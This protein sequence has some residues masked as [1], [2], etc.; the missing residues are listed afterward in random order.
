[1]IRDRYAFRRRQRSSIV[2]ELIDERFV[3]ST[4]DVE[5]RRA[6]V[7][8]TLNY[9]DELP[10][11]AR[12]SE[13]VAHLRHSPVV[14][15]AG[16]TGSGKTTQIPLALIEA[17]YGIS[18]MIG[19][20]QPRRLAARSVA[21]RIATQMAVTL[22]SE[23]GYAVRFDDQWSSNTLIK[24]M[25]DGLLLAE[26]SSD[27]FLEQYEVLI[28]DEVHERSVNVDFLLGLMKQLLGR[29]GDLKIVLASA[30][31]DVEAFS[32]HFGN[33][34]TVSVQGR[35][36]PVEVVYR[37]P[38][39]HLEAEVLDILTALCREDSEN[40]RDILM[41]LAT[42]REILE[43]ARLIRGRFV[44]A[45][46]VLPLYARLP[47][48]EQ[49]RIFESSKRQRI[50]LATNVAE[51]SLT[52]PGIKY[53]IDL[54]RARINRY[55]PRA[56][57]NRLPIEQISQASADQRSG[58]CGR[59]GPGTC[60]RIYDESEF[61][62]APRYTL[63]EI[64]RS[65]LAS[66]M[67]QGMLLRLGD[68]AQFPFID[69]P[70]RAAIVEA[71]K[72]LTELSAIRN[73]KLTRTGRLMARLPVDP[74]LG[75]MLIEASSRNALS[76]VLIIVAALAAQDP[77]IRPLGNAEKAD[78]AHRSYIHEKS[79][80]LSLL[81]LWNKLEVQRRRLSSSQFSQHL[82]RQFIAKSRYFEW[83]QLHRQLERDCRMLKLK[84]NAKAASYRDV[85]I[86][87]LSGSIRFI[88]HHIE[89]T[90]YQCT[91]GFECYL[92]PGE[93]SRGIKPSWIVIFEIVE[94]SRTYARCV[95]EVQPRW[96]EEVSADLLKYS[97]QDPFWDQKRAEAMI[98]C[99]AT[100]FGLTVIRRRKV[101]LAPVDPAKAREIFI[102]NA[103]VNSKSA[104][105]WDFLENN[106]RLF[107]ELN[108]VQQR[109]RTNDLLISPSLRRVYYEKRIPTHVVN[110]STFDQWYKGASKTEKSALRMTAEDML[111]R[112]DQQ[113]DHN[114]FPSTLV[115]DELALPLRYRYAPGEIDD[116][117][118]I[119]LT[120][121]N[122]HD[123]SQTDLDWLVP[124]YLSR[125][126]EE[127]LRG[128]P[129]RMRKQLL[130]IS[131][132]VEEL[133]SEL[134]AGDIYRRKGFLDT[135]SQLLA[136]NFNINATVSDLAS[137]ALSPLVRMN[138]QLRDHRGKL[139][140]QDRILD[141]LKRRVVAR[142]NQDLGQQSLAASQSLRWTSFPDHGITRSKTIKAG[143]RNYTL[144]SLLRD[145]STSVLQK[146]QPEPPISDEINLRAMCR[147][148]LLAES[149]AVRYLKKEFR[150]EE[151][152]QLQFATIGSG[153]DLFQSLLLAAAHRA[154]LHSRPL[155]Y[156]KGVFDDLVTS[157]KG[158]LI[159]TAMN[160]LECIKRVLSRRSDLTKAISNMNTSLLSEARTDLA[161][162]LDSLIYADFV[163]ETPIHRFAHLEDYLEGMDYRL[164]SLQGG[165]LRDTQNM[166]ELHPIEDRYRSLEIKNPY[167]NDVRELRF[168]IE[169]YR[170]SLFH[171]R[172][173]SKR[174]IRKKVIISRLDEL[175]SADS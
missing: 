48:K 174:K 103:L 145:E 52:V 135:V 32:K 71:R 56:R 80:F 21:Q 16:E 155:P 146:W 3:K 151:M 42:E 88:G 93:I 38:Q 20:T 51:T 73:G 50:L 68:I 33:A 133:M 125:K 114:A 148:V 108:E 9:Q 132:R 111:Q 95:G 15:V 34:P 7:P 70:E 131:L 136:K 139:I 57:I 76:E 78:Q 97:Y 44:N 91:S 175:E 36:Y 173:G 29:R 89:R 106:H 41:F 156:E 107:D 54:G 137:V 23:V 30:T 66:V 165:I 25:T 119:Q 138:V 99:S 45:F 10:I 94:T 149:Q 60:F 63:P 161:Q 49:Q 83:R 101:R 104:N 75:K 74:R 120:N 141:N 162:H 170:L 19:H 69:P 64:K 98:F 140:D 164:K 11:T 8:R 5:R 167:N 124:G 85:H 31:I 144:F 59:I 110:V 123:V 55:S 37:P 67:L 117:I 171:Q 14:I 1:M 168:M 122:L 84:F 28:I 153:M 113:L 154:Y 150:K 147:F 96:I 92:T 77:R 129:K 100:L 18:G 163:F 90:R 109:Q 65:N 61:S 43:W 2:S 105:R 130:P 121:E 26:V 126:C 118:S 13:I 86:S 159:P 157:N 27:R 81:T 102:T 46:E 158:S 22:G 6:L 82:E 40:H 47:P 58:R 12:L 115:L 152:L 72:S 53:V 127:L 169:D 143:A 87:L 17:G 172:L 112:L 4:Q 134:L 62:D 128:L 39:I 35:T 116:G 166:A 142:T 79:E 24:V 160:L